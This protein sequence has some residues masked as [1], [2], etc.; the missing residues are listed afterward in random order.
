[1][2]ISGLWTP[3]QTFKCVDFNCGCELKIIT[4]PQASGLLP[5]R[6]PTCLCGG[7]MKRWPQAALRSDQFNDV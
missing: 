7:P 1:M 5:L 3:D 4:P 6:S 2:G